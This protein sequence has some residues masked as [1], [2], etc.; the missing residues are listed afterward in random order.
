M[1][2]LFECAALGRAAWEVWSHDQTASVIGV[3]SRGL[4]IRAPRRVIFVSFETFCGPL[5]A[6]LH[7]P[8]DQLHALQLNAPAHFSG[9]RLI[10]PSIEVAIQASPAKVWRYPSPRTNARTVEAQLDNVR[11]IAGGVIAYG[12]A[13][14]FSTVLPALLGLPIHDLLALDQL[15]LLDNLFALRQARA[16]RNIPQMIEY[17]T[18]LL[19][20]G[21]GL[22]PSGDDCVLG[23]LLML[24]RWHIGG[25]W[26]ELNQRV[27]EAAYQQ[28]TLLSANLIECAAEGQ[29][30]ERLMKV[31]DGIVTGTPSID[32]CVD[33]VLG[34]G[35]SSGTDALVGMAVALTTRVQPRRPLR[36]RRKT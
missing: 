8:F 7:P 21:H 27:I 24:N 28:T 34:W 14:G 20:R 4:F 31:V 22:T 17:I 19:G 32:E 26:H 25:D 11:Q 15:T 35:N 1:S 3:T 23:L 18:G 10:F 13:E 16:A 12:R 9:G 5:T 36:T 29:A 2:C 30:D 33:C 6:T